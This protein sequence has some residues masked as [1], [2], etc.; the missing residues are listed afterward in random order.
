M[1]LQRKMV[2]ADKPDFQKACDMGDEIGARDCRLLKID[3]T[4]FLFRVSLN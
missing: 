3:D 1:K 2:I 4:L